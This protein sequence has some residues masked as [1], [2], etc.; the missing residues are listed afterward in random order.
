[1]AMLVDAGRWASLT[2]DHVRPSRGHFH[3]HP[4]FCKTHPIRGCMCPRYRQL[5]EK[6]LPHQE[7]TAALTEAWSSCVRLAEGRAVPEFPGDMLCSGAF[8]GLKSTCCLQIAF[9]R[10]P[11]MQNCCQGLRDG[12]YPS[13]QLQAEDLHQKAFPR[14][15]I[16]QMVERHICPMEAA[17]TKMGAL[18]LPWHPQLCMDNSR[19]ILSWDHEPRCL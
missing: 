7:L 9:R 1:M 14:S 5:K 17:V 8:P 2:G 6:W 13:I 18:C 3:H 15:P 16:N 4:P 19:S 11:G 12:C 10:L